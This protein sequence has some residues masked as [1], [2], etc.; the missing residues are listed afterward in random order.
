M[1]PEELAAIPPEMKTLD[2]WVGRRGKRPVAPWSGAGGAADIPAAVNK[3]GTWGT[4]EDALGFVERGGEGVGFVFNG[5][6]LAFLDLDGCLDENGQLKPE[7]VA[8]VTVLIGGEVYVEVSPSGRGLHI[9]APWGSGER[10]VRS[11]AERPWGHLELY[12]SGRYSTVT[13]KG[14]PQGEQA[15]PG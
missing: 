11:R 13:G 14:L 10:P 6:G 8:E 4:F 15:A 3:P 1:T 9:F 5:D 12:F 7:A 2:R